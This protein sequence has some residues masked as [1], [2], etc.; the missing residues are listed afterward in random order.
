MISG[1]WGCDPRVMRLKSGGHSAMLQHS[2]ET[3]RGGTWLPVELAEVHMICL[4]L[5]HRHL[6]DKTAARMI[7]KTL[8]CTVVFTWSSR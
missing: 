8:F 6:L 2:P 4:K 5:K 7:P 1:A 3:Q